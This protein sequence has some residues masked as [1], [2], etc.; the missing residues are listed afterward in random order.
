MKHQIL[1]KCCIFCV[2]PL[3]VILLPFRLGGVLPPVIST[4]CSR[5][6]VISTKRSEWRNLAN[7]LSFSRFLDFALRAP[8]DRP[9]INMIARH[10]FIRKIGLFPDEMCFS[11]SL[12]VKSAFPRTS[13]QFSHFGPQSKLQRWI[14]DG[15][16][17]SRKGKGPT[18]WGGPPAAI[19]R[20]N[21]H[22]RPALYSLPPCPES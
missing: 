11:P 1:E 5:T 3:T 16:I 12:S 18:K 21:I 2:F 22:R 15:G 20:C 10:A 8:L 9:S 4:D 19:C 13:H 6:T 14:V 7:E 17:G